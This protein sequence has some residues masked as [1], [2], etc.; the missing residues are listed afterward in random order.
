MAAAQIPALGGKLTRH[1]VSVAGQYRENWLARQLGWEEFPAEL[2]EVDLSGTKVSGKDLAVLGGCNWIRK[3]DLANTGVG[4]AD[5]AQLQRLD[6]LFF[7]SLVN[8]KVTDAAISYLGAMQYLYQLKVSG[9]AVTYDGMAALD[10]QMGVSR[11]EEGMAL[12]HLPFAGV[13]VFAPQRF[14]NFLFGDVGPPPLTYTTQAITV[15]NAAKIAPEELE[16]LAHLKSTHDFSVTS[17]TKAGFGSFEMLAGFPELRGV[18]IYGGSVS[19][20]DLKVIARLPKLHNLVINDWRGSSEA[21]EMFGDNDSLK[22]LDLKLGNDQS[23]D[24]TKHLGGFEA[25]ESLDLSYWERS[26]VERNRPYRVHRVPSKSRRRL[27]RSPD[28]KSFRS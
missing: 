6:N 25:S 11:F 14:G 16:H 7:L 2:W 4:D 3:L 23:L 1:G 20:T 24:A 28:L 18:E 21:F 22:R 8:T 26:T 27:P 9:S 19:D 17:D 15:R 5:V 12:E 10:R 13:E